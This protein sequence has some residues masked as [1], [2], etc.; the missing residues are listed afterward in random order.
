MNWKD[1]LSEARINKGFE[2]AG[3]VRPYMEKKDYQS[4]AFEKDYSTIINSASFRRLQD[5]TQVFPLDKSDFVRTRLTH[6][7]E[8]S[9]VAKKLGTMAASIIIEKEKPD[10]NLKKQIKNIPD[11]LMCAG[12]LHDIGNPPFGH[13]GEEF[14]G[15]WFI[16]FIE[17]YEFKN[18]K[19]SKCLKPQMQ[20]DL[21]KYEG[22][23]QALRLVTRLHY[24]DGDDGMNLTNAVLN[25]IL[26]YPC[27]SLETKKTD[28][29]KNKKN[30]YFFAEQEIFKQITSTTGAN[31]ARHPLTYLLEAAD[32][33]AYHTA[34]IEDG[35][36]K[37]LYTFSQ[38][39]DFLKK[40]YESYENKISPLVA[41]K[42]KIAMVALSDFK[43]AAQKKFG[44]VKDVKNIELV[45]VQNWVKY[46]QG[47][48]SYCVAYSFDTNYTE[49][50]K[51]EYQK[52]LLFGTFHEF[53]KKIL[54]DLMKEF[55]FNIPSILKLEL[56]G[57]SILGFLLDKFVPA[58]LYFDTDIEPSKTDKKLI[59][60]IS[61]NYI[62]E[63]KKSSAGKDENEKLYLRLLLAVDFISGMTDSY[64][65]DLYRELNGNE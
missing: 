23:A 38:L 8:T 25:T 16:K 41:E 1:L 54:F 3:D 63:Y 7:I 11:I 10:E 34:D 52:D 12:L 56:S 60:L 26:K 14:I 2:L 37:G 64:A 5:K 44:G 51:G 30:G 55:I 21:L 15:E 24:L 40:D 48:F 53:T 17:N 4:T 33:I 58:V 39:E 6:S 65:K 18:K 31:D 9:T 28:D 43:N 20:N 61:D 62:A 35:F 42:T 22:N 46:L 19:I 29:I 47:W 36:K 45:A 57:K 32:D 13:A 50:I 27:S 49:I 59:N